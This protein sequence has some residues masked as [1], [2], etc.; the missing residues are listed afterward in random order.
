MVHA[1]PDEFG[2]RHLHLALELGLDQVG[3]AG[4]R[5]Q[6]ALLH[7]LGVVAE[8]ERTEVKPHRAVLRT[9]RLALRPVAQLR[10]HR[11]LVRFG[12]ALR[13]RPADADRRCRR[14][15]HRRAGCPSPR[16]R[17]RRPRRRSCGSCRPGRRSPSGRH[18]PR[19]APFLIDAAIHHQLALCGRLAGGEDGGDAKG[20]RKN[21]APCG[22]GH[23]GLPWCMRCGRRPPPTLHGI[24]VCVQR[25]AG[26]SNGKAPRQAAWP[27]HGRTQWHSQIR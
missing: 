13:R 26:R 27:K 9:L 7:V 10:Q 19:A 20:E 8:A 22:P 2:I 25:I 16:V 12:E 23:G 15:R 11:R 1:V 6:L 24:R 4:G 17:G 18:W 5:R 3:P 14:T 21:M